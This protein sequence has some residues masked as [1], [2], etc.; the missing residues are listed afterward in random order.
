MRPSSFLLSGLLAAAVVYPGSGEAAGI[1][2]PSFLPGDT[3][4]ETY[5]FVG[6]LEDGSYAQVQLSVTNLGPGSGH[7]ICRALWVPPKGKPFTAHE[8]VSRKDVAHGRTEGGEWLRIG[9]CRATAGETLAIEAPLGG[10]IVRLEYDRPPVAERP[11]DDVTTV[12]GKRHRTELLL[13]GGTVRATFERPSGGAL[14]RA[15]G[16][17]ADHS[18]SLVEPKAL[19]RRWVRFRALRGE[20]APRLLL[21]REA[22]GGT[23]GPL[24]RRD[25]DGYR[26]GGTFTLDRDGRGERSRFVARF[27]GEAGAFS[28]R[29]SRI[30]FRHEPLQELGLLGS[31]VSPL[32]GAPVTYTHRATLSEEGRPDVPGIL[33]VSLAED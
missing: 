24:W 14:L 33:E 12:G 16:G 26:R 9:P 11:P 30:L 6:D 28:I 22:F 1:L 21:A 13:A 8:R 4:A 7:G 29:T 20:A 10:R 15:G 2:Q 31:L 32:V 3:Y 18:L 5:T 27:D 17:Y 25:G 23:F 19:A